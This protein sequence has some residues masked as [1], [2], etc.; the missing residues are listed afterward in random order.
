MSLGDF[1]Y[2][3]CTGFPEDYVDE[4]VWQFFRELLHSEGLRDNLVNTGADYA[5]M[6][7]LLNSLD[8]A[9][10]VSNLTDVVW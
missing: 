3:R 5:Q 6:V 9:T 8:A 10:T 1:Y 2:V 4:E 7:L